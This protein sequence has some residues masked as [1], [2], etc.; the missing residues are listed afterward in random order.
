MLPC[1]DETKDRVVKLLS[2][3]FRYY[4]ESLFIVPVFKNIC[5]AHGTGKFFRKSKHASAISLKMTYIFNDLYLLSRVFETV[6]FLF[7]LQQ[8]RFPTLGESTK[9]FIF[10]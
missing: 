1:S 5:I 2:I 8:G 7:F 9:S 6:N 4:N 10:A 3:S